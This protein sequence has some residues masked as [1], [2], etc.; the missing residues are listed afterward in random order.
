MESSSDDDEKY[1]PGLKTWIREEIKHMYCKCYEVPHTR[2]LKPDKS[3]LH[4]LLMTLKAGRS[5]DFCG[6]LQVSPYT[7][8]CLVAEISI[9]PVFTNNSETVPQ[10]PVEE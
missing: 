6:E 1:R 2:T 8:D 5:K 10:T 7:F 4:H 9:D 3:F